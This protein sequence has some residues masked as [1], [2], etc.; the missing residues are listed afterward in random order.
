MKKFSLIIIL[1]AVTI[2][3]LKAQLSIN[4]EYRPR[5]EF[6]HGYKSMFSEDDNAAYFISQRTRL[7]LTYKNEKYSLRITGQDV[8]VWGDESMFSST[9]VKGDNASVD[10]Y[11]AWFQLNVGANSHL[12]IGRQEWAYDDQRLLAKRNWGQSGM[13]YDGLLLNFDNKDFRFD[14]GLSLNNDAENKVGNEY[15]PDKMKFLDFIYLSKK[16]GQSSKITFKGILSGYQKE[17]G[18]ETIY[19]MGTYG[20]FF[21]M[22]NAKFKLDAYFYH[23][24]GTN[25]TSQNVNAYL[26]SL[27][28]M[29]KLSNTINVGPG[30]DLISGNDPSGNSKTDH[31]FD[32]LYGGRHRFMG[33]MD[34]FSSL[35]KSVSDAGLIDVFAKANL[36]FNKKNSLNIAYHHFATQKSISNPLDI[37]SDFKK[38]LGNE[39]DLMYKYKAEIPAGLR[40]GFA[41]FNA[42]K[43]MEYLQGVSNNSANLQCFMWVQ[44]AFTPEIFTTRTH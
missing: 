25:T 28:A 40:I 9:S 22:N 2:T 31:S 21:Q 13:T 4:A 29:Y 30:L 44:L 7:G 41:L 39:I 1:A 32:L 43:T 19:V 23:Q 38:S 24:T 6:R 8:R 34:Y 18:S 3:T 35:S 20:P 42:S 16:L 10:L 37:S 11:E 26:F 33:D 36:S 5:G 27:K 17:E 15:T 12:K 14:L